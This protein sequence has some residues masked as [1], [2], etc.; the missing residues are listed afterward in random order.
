MTAENSRKWKSEPYYRMKNQMRWIKRKLQKRN[1][2]GQVYWGKTTGRTR[3]KTQS[4]SDYMEETKASRKTK[5]K[6]EAEATEDAIIEDVPANA[7]KNTE[8][9][10]SPQSRRAGKD[11][12]EARR[13]RRQHLRPPRAQPQHDR[14]LQQEHVRRVRQPLDARPDARHRYRSA[15]VVLWED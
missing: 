15:V 12:R 14:H 10:A 5:R 11:E 3:R 4:F 6:P 9:S 1:D 13:L 2:D 7:R 8:F